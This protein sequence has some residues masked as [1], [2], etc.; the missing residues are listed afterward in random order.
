MLLLFACFVVIPLTQQQDKQQ[1]PKHYSKIAFSGT[2]YYIYV[3]G[4]QE[5]TRMG[6]DEM[7]IDILLSFMGDNC[8]NFVLALQQQSSMKMR[9]TNATLMSFDGKEIHGMDDIINDKG[10]NNVVNGNSDTTANTTNNNNNMMMSDNEMRMISLFVSLLIPGIILCLVCT[11]FLV[12]CAREAIDWEAPSSS[13]SQR[14]KNKSNFRVTSS[15]SSSSSWIQQR[16][17]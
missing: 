7:K 9:V 3:P 12:R 6:K 17:Q 5:V 4:S 15:S 11:L 2:A 10:D 8:T 14:Q 13:L 16:E 1:Q